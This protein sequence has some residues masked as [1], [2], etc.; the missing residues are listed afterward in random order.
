MKTSRR[1]LTAGWRFLG[2]NIALRSIMWRRK[3]VP[4]LFRD[5][6]KQHPHKTMFVT[7]ER[8]WTFQ[9]VEDY[10]SKIAN[11]FLQ[12][13]LRA[14]D[15]V[16]LVMENRADVV[17]VW[18]A[19]SKIGVATA[20]VNYNLRQ[21]P[22]LHCIS[23]VN[24]KAIIFTPQMAPHIMEIT[25]SIKDKREARFFIYGESEM[26]PQ[27]PG[28]NILAN[29]DSMPSELPSYRG[30]LDDNLLYIFTS[31][32]TGM[33]K[34]A[35]IKHLRYI[36]CGIMIH[37]MMPLKS[38]DRMYHY[39]PLY[40][41]AGGV[42][43][44]SQ[45]VLFGLS[46]AMAPKFSASTFWEDCI[47]YQCT[48]TQYIGEIC[49]YLY[50]QAPK[51]TDNQH[52]IRLMFG[53]GLRPQLWMDFKNRF[54]I[55]NLRELYGS[56]EGNANIINIDG[57]VGSVGFVPTICR[58]SP[59]LASFIYN[60][61]IIKIDPE[62]GTPER[63]K[64]GL[65]VRVRP[66]EPGELVASIDK[67]PQC[68]FDGYTDS[69]ATT[70]KIYRNVFRKGDECFASGDILVF[71]NDGY[72]FFKDRTGDTFRWKGE[73]VS[74]TEVEDVIS[75]YADLSDSVVYGVEIPGLEGKAGMAALLDPAQVVDVNKLLECLRKEL[76]AYAVPLFIRIAEKLEATGT[77]KLPKMKL[78]REG[79]DIKSFE[80][81][82]YFLDQ[83]EGVYV[84]FDQNLLEK[85]VNKELR[86]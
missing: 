14:G 80:D 17:F 38:S 68:R 78:M 44:T 15:N 19:L 27:F 11:Y 24:T 16:A 35:V 50:N 51:V 32:T 28:E 30:S 69:S 20:V 74:T 83:S 29:L 23:V 48:V 76:P 9:D 81:P 5:R 25:A 33:P 70:R 31:G 49:R 36:F 84:R 57:T 13:D 12:R 42:L 43:G 4:M 86:V 66:N 79:F 67:K 26:Y 3:T 6:V 53:N 54:R 56:T 58:V 60:L 18:L 65:C 73:N 1:D 77:F 34:A 64:R 22:L 21:S 59:F 63:N 41:I 8:E 62:S 46:G 2:S 75:K 52:S 7:P 45:S 37:H 85:L 39:L 47:K 40:H 10:T 72:L 55:E 61:N 71:N 82:V